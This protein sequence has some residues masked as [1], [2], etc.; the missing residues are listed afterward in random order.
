LA[1]LNAETGAE[2]RRAPPR[3]TEP[4]RGPEHDKLSVFAGRWQAE[5]Q[6]YGADEGRMISDET[7]EWLSGG[8]FLVCR[9]DARVG[10]AEHKGIGYLAWDEGRRIHT[11]RL[12]DNLGYDRLYELSANGLVWTF[13][14]ERERATYAFSED[15][16]RIDIRWEKSD[17]GVNFRPL[18]ELRARRVGGLGPTQH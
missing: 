14:G 17:D 18:C 2:R 9:F 3:E 7:W 8:F 12:I 13:N 10:E 5:G 16:R 11:C 15:C 6:T 1:S 4:A